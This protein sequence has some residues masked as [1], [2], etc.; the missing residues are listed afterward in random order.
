MKVLMN[1]LVYLLALTILNGCGSFP[2]IDP[3]EAG[4]INYSRDYVRVAK[5]D[6]NY[7]KL[8]AISEAEN[9][10]LSTTHKWIALSPEDWTKLLNYLDAAYVYMN[11]NFKSPLPKTRGTPK[12]KEITSLITKE[13]N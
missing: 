1:F 9:R 12:G 11:K 5:F 2:V 7:G 4:A 10:P 3:L 6:F 13:F 8:C